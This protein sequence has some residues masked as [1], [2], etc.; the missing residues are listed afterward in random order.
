MHATDRRDFLKIGVAGATGLIAN[1][2][3][4]RGASAAGYRSPIERPVCG[5]IGAGIRY[6]NL[7]QEATPFGPCA[8]ICDVDAQQLRNAKAVL[9]MLYQGA[10]VA[11]PRVDL[12]EDYRRVL[13]RSDIDV[14]I[15]ATPDHWHAKMAIE[16]MHAG[17]DVYCE[18][19]LTLT[20]AEGRLISDA[21][22]QTGRVFQVGTQQ[23]SG[24][25]F[26][27]AAA[28][29]RDGRLGKT[30]RITCG[31][32]DSPS[33]DALP[34]AA[35]PSELNWNRWLGPAPYVPYRSA[36]EPT[37]EGYG[38]H[39]PQSRCHAHFRWWYE[40]AGGKLTDWG[41]HHV[42]I[43][44]WALGKSDGS[45]GK[46]TIDPLRVEHPV[47]LEDGVPTLDDRF[48]TATSYHLRV[49]FEDGAELDIVDY[50]DELKF[51]NGVMFQ[52]DDGRYFV[53]RG[54]LTGKPVEQL[55]ENPLPEDYL[56]KLYDGPADPSAE[57]PHM[58]NFMDCLKT[59]QTPI[60]D[61]E[62]HHRHL[63]VCHA[64]NIA[65]RLGRK[66]TF[67]TATERFVGDE[68][69]NQMIARE[70]RKGFEIDA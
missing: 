59:G 58:Q 13:D 51:G 21:V 40:Y 5:Y 50:S 37:N 67:D 6:L 31:I 39:L 4:V 17:K 61:A 43:A 69:A 11:P 63:T 48:N 9:E 68:R 10:G 12:C 19:P 65:M 30:R 34:L 64:A 28:L 23:R 45:V 38:G 42:D 29:L 20:I 62:S 8:A 18:K 26:Q 2:H 1:A 66:L 35:P 36:P 53:N 49:T 47:P 16:A 54:K 52:C 33:S 44:L 15:I 41:A 3:A 60:S 22:K 24:P 46:F 55:A 32:N 7:V 70:N 56:N 14:V 25:D 27:Q 57:H